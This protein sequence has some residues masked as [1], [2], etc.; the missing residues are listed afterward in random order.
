M[1]TN[2]N[3]PGVQSRFSLQGRVALV[4][5]AGSGLGAHFAA[6]LAEAGA[7]V[8]CV[9]RRL[10]RVEPFLLT[11]DE[12]RHGAD[13]FPTKFHDIAQHHVTL[14]GTSPFEGL[15][16]SPAHLRLRLEQELRNLS[17]RLRRRYVALVDDPEVLARA[18]SEVVPGFAVELQGLLSLL[19]KPAPKS[20][21]PADV[22]A[23]AAAAFDW[24][25]HLVRAVSPASG[26]R[27]AEQI[28][29]DAEALMAAVASAAAHAN[30]APEA[31]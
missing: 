6:V 24:P 16:V 17:L 2:N 31:H 15:K 21:A 28:R 1:S 20:D 14:Y 23:A 19:G 25:Q 13:V 11:A 9:A 18:V 3:N 10:L 22:L 30:H 7:R 5:G 8:V 12:V 29:V 26:P 4:T 27:S